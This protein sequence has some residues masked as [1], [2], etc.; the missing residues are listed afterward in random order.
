MDVVEHYLAMFEIRLRNLERRVTPVT[1]LDFV[2]LFTTIG[3]PVA[4][5]IAVRLFKYLLGIYRL[6]L[7]VAQTV[8][9]VWPIGVLV[10][11]LYVLCSGSLLQEWRDW[12][13]WQVCWVGSCVGI[14]YASKRLTCSICTESLPDTAWHFN[15]QVC[16]GQVICWS[17]VRRHS[18]GVIDDARP[19]MLCP[20]LPCKAIVPDTVVKRAIRREQWNWESLDMFGSLARRKWRAYSRWS[21][22]AG[23]ARAC[24]AR[25]E[26]VLHCPAQGCDHL[27][28]LPKERRRRKSEGEP[29]SKW[30]PQTWALGRSLGFY[31]P[32]VTLRGDDIRR[33]DCPNCQL[34]FCVLCG[35]PWEHEESHAEHSGKSCLEHSAE[36]D[37]GTGSRRWG[38]AKEC[39][40]CSIRIVR[41]EGCNHM[42][43]TQCGKEWCWVC[44]S[45]WTAAHYGCRP[46]TRQDCTIL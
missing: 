24:Q 14:P 21:L 25:M 5:G 6:P 3:I 18:E 26:D 40:G 43:C 35:Y 32:P 44:Q 15:K 1:A 8:W 28:L 12:L 29:Q 46:L 7:W 34:K 9:D 41:S 27:W 22:R 31:K 4:A 45:S 10:Y 42:T 37:D 16:C 13:A 20:M 19:D 30:N 39:P 23:L 36:F 17:C 11:F 33:V 2:T 38:G